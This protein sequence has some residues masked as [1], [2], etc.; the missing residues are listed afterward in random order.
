MTQPYRVWKQN[1]HARA[2]KKLSA[3][4]NDPGL[5]GRHSPNEPVPL[6]HFPIVRPCQR[7]KEKDGNLVAALFLSV[8]SQGAFQGGSHTVTMHQAIDHLASCVEPVQA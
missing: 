6:P 5:A 7:V 8:P 3:V 2:E 1:E 4:A